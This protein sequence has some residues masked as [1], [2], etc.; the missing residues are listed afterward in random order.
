MNAASALLA[1]PSSKWSMPGSG[2]S[3]GSV[4]NAPAASSSAP[5]APS[6]RIGLQ[7]RY[8]PSRTPSLDR[9]ARA[10]TR[11]S[12]SGSTSASNRTGGRP[13]SRSR[14]RSD[15]RPPTRRCRARADEARHGAALRERAVQRGERVAVHAVGDDDRDAPRLDAAVAGPREQ[16][17]RRRDVAPRAAAVRRARFGSGSG[18]CDAEAV[19][20]A[21]A[22]ARPPRCAASRPCA[23]GRRPS[24][25]WSAR[26][27]TRRR[28][29]PARP[30]SGCCQN[31]V[32]CV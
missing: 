23:R 3:F 21:L 5:D 32:A 28:C 31:S 24:A 25:P 1:L 19:R 9:A 18:S 29:A 27:G 15:R 16:R 11:V 2:S 4:G 13:P 10:L 26:S 14:L 8:C 30:S 17:Q 12:P 6:A 20:D 7:C 22:R